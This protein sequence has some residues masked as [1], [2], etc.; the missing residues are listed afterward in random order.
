MNQYQEENY[1]PDQ[2]EKG[3]GI[4]NSDLVNMMIL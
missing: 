2:L 3:T 4:E 1:Q